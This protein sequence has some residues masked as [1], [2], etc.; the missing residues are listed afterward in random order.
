MPDFK[1]TA[2]ATGWKEGER[3]GL[4]SRLGEGE[5]SFRGKRSPRVIWGR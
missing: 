2:T 4:G 5:I 3:L 1:S